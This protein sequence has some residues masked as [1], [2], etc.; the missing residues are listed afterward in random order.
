[1]EQKK[2]K[3]VYC[4]ESFRVQYIGNHIM[5]NHEELA[6][7]EFIHVA[8][9]LKNPEKIGVVGIPDI[10][11]WKSKNMYNRKKYYLC[12]CCSYW[13]TSENMM[14]KH[15]LTK[16]HWM[17][18]L[19]ILCDTHN[20]NVDV[21][22]K[23]TVIEDSQKDEIIENQKK[24]IIE[25]KVIINDLRADKRKIDRIEEQHKYTIDIYEKHIETLKSTQKNCKCAY[26]ED[27]ESWNCGDCYGHILEKAQLWNLLRD[28]D[29]EIER[30]KSFIASRQ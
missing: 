27:D 28:K 1:M 26:D 17:D 29:A 22:T 21:R 2:M 16:Q 5:K 13:T 24:K 19:Q 20:N 7:N 12:W 15:I 30:L 18:S 11:Y 8:N 14:K 4:D 25:E 23:F 6:K 9:M 10:N 3:C